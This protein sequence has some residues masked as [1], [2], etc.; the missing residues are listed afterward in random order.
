MAC[1]LFV[2]F[3]LIN[4]ALTNLTFYSY[5]IRKGKHGEPIKVKKSEKGR[6]KSKQ[7]YHDYQINL[8]SVKHFILNLFT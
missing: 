1:A 4:L 8:Q 3:G 2:M 5:N 7:N 6:L